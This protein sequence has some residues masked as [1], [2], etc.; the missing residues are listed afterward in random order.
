[1]HVQTDYFNIPHV[2]LPP[3]GCYFLAAT[4]RKRISDNIR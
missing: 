1:M 3:L 4:Q 2:G